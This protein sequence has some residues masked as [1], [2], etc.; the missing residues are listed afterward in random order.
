MDQPCAEVSQ[1]RDFHVTTGA[2]IAP[3]RVL[4]Q[5]EEIALPPTANTFHHLLLEAYR[6]P[7]WRSYT[8]HV[9]LTFDPKRFGIDV[10]QMSSSLC[11][12]QVREAIEWLATFIDSHQMSHAE[13]AQRREWLENAAVNLGAQVMDLF[14]P[15]VMGAD[16]RERVSVVSD[17]QPGDDG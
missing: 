11:L 13:R 17:Y 5:A 6:D 12:G 14:R 15:K 3:V 2:S 10:S 9:G 8:F 7:R 4:E 1:S 16:V